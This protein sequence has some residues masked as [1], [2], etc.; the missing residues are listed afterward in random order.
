MYIIEFKKPSNYAALK[1]SESSHILYLEH[2]I[3]AHMFIF[4]KAPRTWSLSV[5]LTLALPRCLSC[6]F[7]RS[8]SLCLCVCLSN[9][10][11]GSVFFM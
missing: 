4:N 9:F 3:V 11:S 2:M 6:T 10:K 5:A 1:M 7:C 8:L